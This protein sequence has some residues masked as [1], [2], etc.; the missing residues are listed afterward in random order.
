MIFNVMTQKLL[1]RL[2]TC[3]QLFSTAEHDLHYKFA[4]ICYNLSGITLTSKSKV[5]VAHSDGSVSGLM[6]WMAAATCL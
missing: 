6:L 3:L 1:T 5:H 2:N 4:A